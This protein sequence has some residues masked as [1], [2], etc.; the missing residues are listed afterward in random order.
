MEKRVSYY[1]NRNNVLVWLAAL[2]TV[3]SVGLRIAYYCGKGADT[4]TMWLLI[5]LPVAACL[6]FALQILLDGQEHFYRTA[7]PVLMMA[8]YFSA[9]I[10]LRGWSKRLVFL[11]ILVYLAFYIFYRLITAGRLRA[12]WALPLMF[13]GALG[14]QVYDGRAAFSSGDLDLW[15]SCGIDVL[16]LLAGL[17][18]VFAMRPHTDGQYHHT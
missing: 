16:A 4:T 3:G 9:V 18:T 15:F 14:V 1:V 7:T 17:L 10:I 11:S 2:L 12:T 8:V 6:I 13:L 5:V